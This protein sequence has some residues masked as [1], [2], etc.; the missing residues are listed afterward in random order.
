M[1]IWSRWQWKEGLIMHHTTRKMLDGGPQY[2]GS[3]NRIYS[4]GDSL[5]I[6]TVTDGTHTLAQLDWN[7]IPVATG[8]AKRKLTD[9]HDDILGTAI[10]LSRMFAQAAEE[11]GGKVEV[12]MSSP[13][14]QEDDQEEINRKRAQQV[15]KKA[16]LK[17]RNKKHRDRRVTW[18]QKHNPDADDAEIA[19][20]LAR[21]FGDTTGLV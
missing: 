3:S 7:G 5:K 21:T 12:L 1:G 15:F 8:H 20:W 10:A 9:K 18:Y 11:Y 6:T 19:D 16:S 4:T 17:S 13:E 2:Q 14:Q